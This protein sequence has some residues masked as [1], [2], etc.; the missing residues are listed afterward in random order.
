MK[1]KPLSAYILADLYKAKSISTMFD[2]WISVHADPAYK[3]APRV[4]LDFE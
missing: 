3:L 2:K 4:R 1:M